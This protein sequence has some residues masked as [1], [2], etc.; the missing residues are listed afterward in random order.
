MKNQMT[1]AMHRERARNALSG[2]WGKMALIVLVS[3]LIETVVSTFIGNATGVASDSTGGRFINFILNNLIF[4]ALTYGLYN[5]ALQVIRGRSIEVGMVLSIFKGEYYLP[6]LLINLVQYVVQLVVG[7]LV[8]LPVLITFGT[9]VY[10]GMM[11]D[12]VSVTQ[13]QNEMASNLFLAAVMF[14]FSLL[15]LLISLFVSGV[16]QFA[17]W[18]KIDH[19]EFGVGTALKEALALMK[20]NFKQ[21]LFLELSFVGWYIVGA[22]ALLIGLLW[23]I[24]YNHVALA[25]L[26]DSIREEKELII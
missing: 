19:P 24:P 22:M 17:V 21:Y 2:K 15:M 12:T 5:A 6:M 26:Y 1:N 14:I 4:F 9:T 10:L 23:V 20:G 16:F 13:Y 8:L 18:T 11:F 7:L 25:S 3:V